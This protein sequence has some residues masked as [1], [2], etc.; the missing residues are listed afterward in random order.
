MKQNLQHAIGEQFEYRCLLFKV[1]ESESCKG[2]SLYYQ[3]EN[4]CMDEL[5]EFEPCD[6]LHR[7]DGKNVIFVYHGEK[8]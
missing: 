7:T 4:H 8:E 2:C 3:Q 5:R 1:K 6:S